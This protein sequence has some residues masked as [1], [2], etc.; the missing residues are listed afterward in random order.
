MRLL[1]AHSLIATLLLLSACAGH[2]AVA[3]EGPVVMVAGIDRDPDSVALTNRINQRVEGGLVRQLRDRGYRVVDE[4]AVSLGTPE[5]GRSRRDAGEVIGVARAVTTPPV[6]LLVLYTI[7]ATA[8]SGNYAKVIRTRVTGRIVNV[9]SGERLGAFETAFPKP[10]HAPLGCGRDCILEIAGHQ[11]EILSRDLGSILSAY[12]ES[13]I[14]GQKDNLTGITEKQGL[15]RSYSLAFEQFS[16]AEI[17]RIEEYLVAF[18]GYRT[19]RP[20]RVMQLHAEYWYDTTAEAARM[21]RNLR[22]MLD[23]LGVQGRVAFTG[24]SFVVRKLPK[25]AR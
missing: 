6:D 7:Y 8:E 9:S 15:V 13:A 24:D 18:S 25:P 14:Q 2:P 4:T 5:T 10:R 20:V 22:K 23:Y 3:A 12:I 16:T 17:T 1:F 19:Y 21:N 11:A